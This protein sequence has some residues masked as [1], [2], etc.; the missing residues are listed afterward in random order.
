MGDQGLRSCYLL[1]IKVHGLVFQLEIRAYGL[2]FVG[3]VL[4]FRIQSLKRAAF[5]PIEGQQV[6]EDHA[7]RFQGSGFRVQ[8]SGFQCF[9]F[10]GS[11]F[12]G[13]GFHRRGPAGR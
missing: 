9:G 7:L 5:D 11:G 1:G 10:Q 2:V 8:G 3:S 4:R 13:F 6:C 12:Q